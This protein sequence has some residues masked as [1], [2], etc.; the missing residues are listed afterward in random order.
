MKLVNHATM[1]QLDNEDVKELAGNSE[2]LRRKYRL[3]IIKKF[4]SYANKNKDIWASLSPHSEER[5]AI[6]RQRTYNKMLLGVGS[7]ANFFFYQAFLTGTYEYRNYEYV[8]MRNLPIVLKVAISTS[9][10]GWM[11]YLMYTDHLYD[12][13]LYRISLKYRN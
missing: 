12:E 4:M 6:S 10:V 2:K 3:S 9:M 7:V 8:R 13:D 11:G 1:C 5:I